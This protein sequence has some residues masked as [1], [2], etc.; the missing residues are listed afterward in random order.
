MWSN[1]LDWHS[2][3]DFKAF[4][5][6][7]YINYCKALS[8]KEVYRSNH[9]HTSCIYLRLTINV[10]V[11]ERNTLKISDAKQTKLVAVRWSAFGKVRR[12]FLPV[13]A[14]ASQLNNFLSGSLTTHLP[15]QKPSTAI[16]VQTNRTSRQV[17]LTQ[18]TTGRDQKELAGGA[19]NIRK[20]RMGVAVTARKTLL[21]P[22]SIGDSQPR[23]RRLPASSV[24]SA[25]EKRWVNG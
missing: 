22:K 1:T 2:M 16:W 14:W 18:I 19:A 10:G 7:K 8:A 11:Q 5:K 17:W 15:Q 4:S 24:H 25:T 9:T 13:S 3:T 23:D 21:L 12:L 6:L 20:E